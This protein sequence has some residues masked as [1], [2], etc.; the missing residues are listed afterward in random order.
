L[1]K[2]GGGSV[3]TVSK[4]KLL[5][6][7]LLS[8]ETLGRRHTLRDSFGQDSENETGSTAHP[9]ESYLRGALWLGRNVSTLI[10]ELAEGLDYFRSKFMKEVAAAVSDLDLS[11]SRHRLNLLAGSSVNESLALANRCRVRARDIMQGVSS[12]SSGDLATFQEFLR[13]LPIESALQ[14]FNSE[15]PGKEV[16]RGSFCGESSGFSTSRES[17]S[18]SGKW[19]S[20]R[21]IRNH[22]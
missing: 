3:V 10:E 22:S 2:K 15:K 4:E 18:S 8:L 12:L 19:S 16:N 11:R 1:K 20:G 9:S 21:K 6:A 17:L 14:P 13:T 5:E 7:S